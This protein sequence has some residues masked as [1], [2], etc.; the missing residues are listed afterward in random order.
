MNSIRKEWREDKVRP[1]PGN[2]PHDRPVSRV[3]SSSPKRVCDDP[4]PTT[5]FPKL[6]TT[7]RRSVCVFQA[8]RNLSVRCGQAR[9][10]P[11][12]G[13][14]PP[15]AGRPRAQVVER[16]GR[17]TP[18]SSSAM[19]SG[20]LFLDR[21]GRHQSPSPLHR[22]PQINMRSRAAWSKGDLS[23]LPARGR[24]YFALTLGGPDLDNRHDFPVC[25][26]KDP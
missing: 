19:S 10:K 22:H 16:A 20:R 7:R 13:T 24:F 3:I 15:P 26:R 4:F 9:T 17:I 5:P 2:P 8:W 12:G 23:T 1:V 25:S 21:V 6:H 11:W 18:F 14:V